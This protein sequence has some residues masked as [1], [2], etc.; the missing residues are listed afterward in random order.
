MHELFGGSV[1]DCP[2]FSLSYLFLALDLLLTPPSY[3]KYWLHKQFCHLLFAS[4]SFHALLS[5]S[6]ALWFLLPCSN[7]STRTAL[8]HSSN[9]RL[10]CIYTAL[11]S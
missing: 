1:M 8:E 2:Y 4:S 5:R 6:I 10:F 9:F 3:G 7:T 11:V